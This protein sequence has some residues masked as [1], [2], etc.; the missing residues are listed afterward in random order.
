MQK[1]LSPRLGL[2]ALL[3]GTPRTAFVAVGMLLATS[4]DPALALFLFADLAAAA[5]VGLRLA[6]GD[7]VDPGADRPHRQG[8]D[9]DRGLGQAAGKGERESEKKDAHRA[10]HKAY[11]LEER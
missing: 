3:P 4:S 11:L 1:P 9:V 2:F 10:A 5:L 8:D 7:G 6:G